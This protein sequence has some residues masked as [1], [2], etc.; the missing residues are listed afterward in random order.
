MDPNTLVNSLILG[1]VVPF[2][3]TIVKQS[4]F[5]DRVNHAIALGVYA[6]WAVGTTLVTSGFG[7]PRL[8]LVNFA[9]TLV[10]GTV[11]YQT[12]MKPFGLDDK[13]TAA[14]TLPAFQPPQEDVVIE[15]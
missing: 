5:D 14:T 7:D 3:V 8:F 1:L 10:V 15:G 13:L 6:A 11:T 9:T 2:L 12:I 4:G